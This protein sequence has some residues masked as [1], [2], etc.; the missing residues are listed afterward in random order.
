MVQI[1]LLSRS[2][3]GETQGL[4]TLTC[5]PPY[6][7]RVWR[8]F[9]FAQCVRRTLKQ[10][11]FH[12]VQSHERIAGCDLYRAGDGVHHTW[13]QQRNRTL[14]PLGRLAT[15]LSPYH[16]YVLAA[17]RHLFQSPKLRAVICNSQMVRREILHRFSTAPE[18]L[19]V[20]Y[21]G[22]D[23]HHFHPSLTAQFKEKT[24]HRLG[25]PQDAFVMLFVGSG[26]HRKGLPILLDAMPHLPEH[27]WLV[28]VGQD[29]R[30]AAMEKKSPESRHRPPG[31]FYGRTTRGSALLRRRGCVGITHAVRSVSQRC[32][33]RDGRWPAT[34]DQPPMWCRRPDHAWRKWHAGGCPGPGT[35]SGKPIPAPRPN[36][37]RNHGTR[38]QKARG[39]VNLGGHESTVVASV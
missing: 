35:A 33:G 24:R 9:S 1:T 8:D 13:L 22:V 12:L 21:S 34:G 38:R 27:T 3:P 37:P 16:R 18:K 23:T 32:P 14:G 26:F 10:Q 36:P 15:T 2:W 4:H 7:G 31:M 39:T 19:H 20:I 11:P 5:N 25:I 30:R 29:R 17:E 6:W 28:V